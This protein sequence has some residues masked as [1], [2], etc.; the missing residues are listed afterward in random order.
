M[1]EAGWRANID[2]LTPGQG[3]G[4][5]EEHGRCLDDRSDVRH[6]YALPLG[7]AIRH[8]VG[9]ARNWKGSFWVV[10]G[11]GAKDLWSAHSPTPIGPGYQHHL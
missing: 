5:H 9:I 10:I 2:P 7:S 8:L 4:S 1:V 6:Q 3:D 11:T